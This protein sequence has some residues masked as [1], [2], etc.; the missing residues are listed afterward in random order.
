MERDGGSIDTG[1][2]LVFR[3]AHRAHESHMRYIVSSKGLACVRLRSISLLWQA[4]K[5]IV[6]NNELRQTQNG[7]LPTP[8]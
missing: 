3:F 1:K 4:H 7:T 8:N 5:E 6:D 2:L